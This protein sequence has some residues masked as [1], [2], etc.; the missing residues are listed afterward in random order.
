MYLLGAVPAR[1]RARI[2]VVE[3]LVQ[4]AAVA[5]MI[6]DGDVN[7]DLPVRRRLGDENLRVHPGGDVVVVPRTAMRRGGIPTRKGTQIRKGERVETVALVVL[8]VNL[9]VLL[10][11]NLVRLARNTRHRLRTS[12]QL[13]DIPSLLRPCEVLHPLCLVESPP[14]PLEVCHRHP[15]QVCLLLPSTWCIQL[16]P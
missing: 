15:C 14:R 10:G 4:A 16:L 2:G 13:R 9:R 12:T 6:A 1:I 5:V 11:R 7:L 3:L 8:T